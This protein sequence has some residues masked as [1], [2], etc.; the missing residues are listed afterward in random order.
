MTEKK[1]D[2]H[3]LN[4]YRPQ[5]KTTYGDSDSIRCTDDVQSIRRCIHQWMIYGLP[6]E[7][8]ALDVSTCDVPA[9]C[10]ELHLFIGRYR[11]D[12]RI[13]GWRPLVDAMLDFDELACVSS[14]EDIEH[15]SRRR[16]DPRNWMR[17]LPP[18]VEVAI[19]AWKFRDGVKG[20]K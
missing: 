3:A 19:D 4:A 9:G 14:D 12:I 17:A 20:A 15:I 7:V 8:D 2:R 6:P 18:T 13:A 11:F 10:T 16:Q 5:Q 1:K